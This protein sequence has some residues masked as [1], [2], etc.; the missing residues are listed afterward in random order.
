MGQ[1]S[2]WVK[3]EQR[4]V[5]WKA[6]GLTQKE[7]C[8][9]EGIGF[10]SLRYWASRSRREGKKLTLVPVRM[11]TGGKVEVVIRGPRSWECAL[12]EGASAQWAA[13]LLRAL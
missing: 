13:D 1:E 12:L 4:V 11:S 9:R 5:G 10:S 2:S 3:W 7:Y 6:S 8:A